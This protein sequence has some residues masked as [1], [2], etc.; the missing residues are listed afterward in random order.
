MKGKNWSSEIKCGLPNY[1][2]DN[3]KIL[4]QKK[5]LCSFYE[6]HV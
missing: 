5:G 6:V 1:T 3:M 2:E 4:P